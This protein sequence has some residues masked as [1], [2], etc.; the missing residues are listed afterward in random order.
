MSEEY[1]VLI[2]DLRMEL[3]SEKRRLERLEEDLE[4][5]NKVISSLRTDYRETREANEKLGLNVE[6]LN[7]QLA[8]KQ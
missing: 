8:K 3:Q 7:H 2:A 4:E 6:E 1:E 5:K